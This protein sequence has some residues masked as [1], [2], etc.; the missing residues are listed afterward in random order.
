L[1][2][3]IGM[4]KKYFNQSYR[5]FMDKNLFNHINIDKTHTYFPNQE[6]VGDNYQKLIRQCPQIELAILGVGNNG[7][8]AF[9]EPGTPIDSQT[10]IVNLTISSRQANAR[11]FNDDI[12]NVPKQAVTMGLKEILQ[13]KKIILIA[14]GKVKKEAIQ[15]L[16]HAKYFDPN[17]PITAL[18]HHSNVIVYTDN[19]D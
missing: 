13:A 16:Q 2:E 4:S 3:Y 11:F 7:H 19:L 8:I 10:H 6:L 18:T 5:Y 14:T 15:H 17:W 1:D 9:N 12:N